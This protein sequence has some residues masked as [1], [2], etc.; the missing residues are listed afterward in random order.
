M[1]ETIHTSLWTSKTWMNIISLPYC[2][3]KQWF[4]SLKTI[5]LLHSLCVHVLVCVL[6]CCIMWYIPI[7]I[8][9]PDAIKKDITECA[10]RN[11]LN[12]TTSRRGDCC[13]EASKE[14][15][16][17]HSWW[18]H[19]SLVFRRFFCSLTVVHIS[20]SDK[21]NSSIIHLQTLNILTV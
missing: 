14:I 4:F 16:T 7:F 18:K 9:E 6:F 11:V 8:K 15:C 21:T 20:H 1:R 10:W 17:E 13:Y 2:H 19:L 3:Q 12:K 5:F